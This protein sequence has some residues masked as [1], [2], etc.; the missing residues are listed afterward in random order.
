M[1]SDDFESIT[2]PPRVLRDVNAGRFSNVFAF[3]LQWFRCSRLPLS[4]TP[5]NVLLPPKSQPRH[6]A[7]MLFA[8]WRKPFGSFHCQPVSTCVLITSP[9]ERNPRSLLSNPGEMAPRPALKIT[10]PF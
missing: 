9:P 4:H 3:Q 6:T 8:Y 2:G 5:F 1:L 7:P 10:R